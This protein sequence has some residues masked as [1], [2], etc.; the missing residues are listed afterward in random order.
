MDILD[1]NKL[2]YSELVEIL[3]STNARLERL[4]KYVSWLN[5]EIANWSEFETNQTLTLQSEVARY[6][7]PWKRFDEL[8]KKITGYITFNESKPE[9]KDGSAF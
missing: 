7:V 2:S 1:G 4:E 5:H 9:K 3:A 6:K 8:D